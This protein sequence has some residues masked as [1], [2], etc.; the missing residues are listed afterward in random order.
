MSLT[1]LSYLG[2]LFVCVCVYYILPKRAKGICLLTFSVLFYSFAMPKQLLVMFAYLWLVFFLAMLIQRVSG[3]WKKVFLVVGIILSVGFLF[4]YKYFNF[5]LSLFFEEKAGFSLVVPI[6]ISYITFQSIAYLVEVYK[7]KLEA[8]KSP[9]AF[10]VYMLLFMKVTAGPIEPP[11][12]FLQGFYSEEK[13]SVAEVQRG[14]LLIALGFV[15]KIVIADVVTPYA[16]AVLDA[17]AEQKG[18]AVLFAIVLYT[19]QI[20]FDFS[21][22]TDIARGSAA[23]FGI[24]LTEN[25]KHPYLSVSIREF[26]RK[27]HISL[28]DWLRQYVYFPLGGSRVGTLRRYLNVMIVFLVSGIWHGASLTFVVWGLLHGIY[29]VLEMLLEPVAIQ[30]RKLLR[31]KENGILHRVIS[32]PRTL[33]LVMAAWV[34]FRAES[35]EQ[36][37]LVFR[38][39]LGEWGEAAIVWKESMP[40]L[41]VVILVAVALL[42]AWLTECLIKARKSF[43]KTLIAPVVVAASIWLVVLAGI[44]TFGTETVNSFI[45]F[46]F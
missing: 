2:F 27:W 40:E 10:F 23:L 41:K 35:L 15:K 44:L 25:F 37:L 46:D 21:G 20:Y 18:F 8:E 12:K 5:T 11:A 24:D 16:S 33:I 1:S 14:I 45:Y 36:A 28:S 17:P 43:G 34:F 19:L 3:R 26:W 9:I 29:Q 6:G 22:Y 31:I 32:I 7:E 42:F 39:L 13:M 38:R 4:F 30:T